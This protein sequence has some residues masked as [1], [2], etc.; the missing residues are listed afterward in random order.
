M[1]DRSDRFLRLY[2]PHQDSLWRFVRSLVGTQHDAEDVVS[3]TITIA[4]ER[5]DSVR[6][7]QAFLSFLF[8]VASRIVKRQRWRKRFTGEYNEGDVMQRP[9][10]DTLPD[11]QADIQ[12]LRDAIRKLPESTRQTVVL[13]E[14]SGLSLEEIRQ[15][16]GGSLSGVKSRLVRGRHMLAKLLQVEEQS[17]SLPEPLR[18][19]SV[20][21]AE[22]TKPA[23]LTSA[24]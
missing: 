14:I 7:E 19:P 24:V 1:E 6:D 4:L 16:Q 11:V 21:T 3:E 22:F 20:T 18:E 13:F 10:A 23:T 8:T 2:I 5:L 9:S 17:S 12:H 15:I